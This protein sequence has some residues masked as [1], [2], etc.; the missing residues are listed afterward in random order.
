MDLD[1][2]SSRPGASQL[3]NVELPGD[4]VLLDVWRAALAQDRPARQELAYAL[5]LSLPTPHVSGLHDR[6]RPLLHFD[7]LCKL[8]VDVSRRILSHL[9]L[10]SVVTCS[11]HPPSTDRAEP[12]AGRLAELAST[13]TL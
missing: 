8:P 7:L 2:V 3:S 11:V 6:V 5:T 13:R 10:Q 4:P 9:D 12:L 1:L